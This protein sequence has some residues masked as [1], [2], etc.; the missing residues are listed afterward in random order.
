MADSFL[1]QLDIPARDALRERASTRSWAVRET[2]FHEGEPADR[3]VIIETGV[4]KAVAASEAGIDTVLALR[5]PGDILGELTAVTGGTR[6]ASVV[7]VEP[8]NA[9]VVTL[10]S[11]REY[12][13][14][15]P[16]AALVLVAVV[17][18]RVAVASRRQVEF[19]SMDASV[20]LSRLLVELA[21]AYGEHSDDGVRF[22]LLSQDELASFCGASRE[23]VARALRAF[24]DAG[25]VTTGRRS[26][27]VVDL[28]ALASWGV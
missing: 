20:R 15:H 23:A 17:S 9:L 13:L 1:S 3:V 24:R 4:V 12:L 26:I 22:K 21:E 11:F 6:T 28:D 8:V 10:G 14:E 2:V 7:A 19:G 16:S 25:L 27:T 5:G 18:S